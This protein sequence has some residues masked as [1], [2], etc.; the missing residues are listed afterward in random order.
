MEDEVPRHKLSSHLAWF[1]SIQWLTL[2]YA[3]Q[4]YRGVFYATSFVEDVPMTAYITLQAQKFDAAA[5]LIP[6]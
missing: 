3:K 5:N 4:L 2:L 6:P 1:F